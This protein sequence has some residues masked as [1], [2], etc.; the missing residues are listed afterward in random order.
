MSNGERAKKSLASVLKRFKQKSKRSAKGKP[1]PLE[2]EQ[3]EP[4]MMLNGDGGEVLFSAGFEDANVP[5]GQIGFFQNISGFTATGGRVEVQNNVRGVGPASEGQKHLE[6]DGVNG[7]FVDV[8]GG[9]VDKLLLQVDYSARP[10]VG[11][12]Q[13]AVEVYWNDQLIRTLSADGTG[14]KTTN[15]RQ[16]EIELPGSSGR[17]EFRS[18]SPDDM[19]GLGG[20]IDNVKVTQELG[21]LQLTEIADQNVPLGSELS[22]NA[23]LLPPNQ[24]LA[25]ATYSISNAPAGMQ[26]DAV[27]GEI[28]WTASQQNI[29]NSD[30]PDDRVV[31]GD[32]VLEFQSGFEELDVPVGGIG[33]FSTVS[34]FTAL[35]RAVE[36]QNN[37][38]AVGAASEGLKHLEL[39]G[40]NSIFRDVST[41]TG[42]QYELVFD[43]S[44]R[45]RV[46]ATTNEIEVWWDGELKQIVSAD[47]TNNRR[48]QF[49]QF[50]FDLSDFTGDLTRLEFRS[51]SVNDTRGLGGL[52]DNIQLF[53]R[54]VEVI[55]GTTGKY[56]VTVSVLDENGRT[57]T[58]TFRICVEDGVAVAPVLDDLADLTI[59]EI[60]TLGLTL[61]TSDSDSTASQL[62]YELLSGPQGATVDEA[63]GELLWTPTE[64]DGPGEFDF[65]VQVTDQSNLSDTQ[66]FKVTVTEVNA[67][68]VIGPI[69]DQAVTEGQSVSLFATATDS[70]LPANDL[71]FSI[72]SGPDGAVI[73]ED[74]GEFTF[75]PNEA[76][77]GNSFTVEVQVDD[78]AG[79]SDSTSFEI[80]VTALPDRPPVLTAVE[81]QSVNEGEQLEVFLMAT[82][83]NGDDDDLVFEL[84]QGPAG[85]TLDADTG[86]FEWTPDESAGGFDFFAI[87]VRVT[88][89]EGLSD[90][91][92][93]QIVVNETNEVP[94]LQ[95]ID[96][97]S[98]DAGQSISVQAVASDSDVPIDTLTFSLTTAP[99]GATVSSEGL[100]QWTTTDDIDAGTF[101][102]TVEVSDGNGGTATESFDVL[103]NSVAPVLSS[104]DNQE[105]DEFQPLQLQLT[106]TDPN[107]D[108][109]DL[110]FELVQGPAGATL[111]PDTGVFEWTPE[112]ICGW[113]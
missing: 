10:R 64:A 8:V 56:D 57:D 16:F 21:D 75:T 54:P 36:I 11:A 78:N 63:T 40:T 50:R 110:V 66:T 89:P 96:D 93:F 22:L 104:I 43:Y 76:Q 2:F 48:T 73:N 90:S 49:R 28:T 111:D 92:Q 105:I 42:D 65:E 58:E 99:E 88:D 74:T 31:I 68:P 53:R 12:N 94:V 98:I 70:D 84:V 29:D 24:N 20:L 37:V 83:P 6:L 47:G 17:L 59:T 101:A 5:A 97:I 44:P 67:P 9:S 79:G 13:N 86:V 33:F 62:E 108:D 100:I 7:I 27:T 95:S 77:A 35:P 103:V 14:S 19:F 61:T 39:D 52:L 46:S 60:E 82:D 85:A 38:R 69:A 3:L 51:N 41:V 26:I 34:G 18:N 102:F 81:D 23:S 25:G 45:P 30:N 87:E 113:F 1:E 4:R 106:A 107:G 91:Q 109:D 32:P 112:R 72:V 71:A 55:E 80:V 15:F